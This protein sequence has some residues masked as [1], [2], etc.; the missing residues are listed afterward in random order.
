MER[1]VINYYTN[2]ISKLEIAKIRMIAKRN[3]SIFLEDINKFNESI[4]EL[5]SIY[6]ENCRFYNMLMEYLNNNKYKVSAD[7]F[8]KLT[9]IKTKQL[10][11]F[12]EIQPI[13]DTIGKPVGKFLP[14]IAL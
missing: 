8:E 1:V 12:K 10:Q 3:S 6:N 11:L 13:I 5:V 9:N 4:Y 14:M 7:T 2:E